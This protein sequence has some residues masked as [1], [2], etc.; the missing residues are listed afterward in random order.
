MNRLYELYY[1][2]KTGFT[3]A[4]KLYLKLNKQV[5]MSQIKAF[6]ER[7]QVH[8][9]HT[10]KKSN[11]AFKPITVYSVNDQW[12][13]DLIDLSRYS[14]WNAGYKYLLCGI[15]VFSRKAFVVAIK[16]KSDTTNAMKSVLDVQKP[17]L[18]QSDNGTE[19]LN[20]SFQN[21]KVVRHI[22]ANVG[23]HNRQGLIE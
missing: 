23:D 10:E 11:R 12:Q 16:M 14:N 18:I 20:H 15:D 1:N 6:L 17:I 3:S 2:P 13:I 9:L 22:T 5:P 19:F 8:Q 4:R 21:S 7:Q